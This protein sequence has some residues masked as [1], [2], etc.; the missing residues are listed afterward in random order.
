MC[1]EA[2]A[3]YFSVLSQLFLDGRRE[4]LKTLDQDSWPLDR[5]VNPD[6]QNTKQKW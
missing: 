5:D 6:L 4:I 2:V 3:A 1:F